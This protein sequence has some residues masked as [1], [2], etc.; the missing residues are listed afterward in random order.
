MEIRQIIEALKKP[1]LAEEHKE[2]TLPGGDRWFY[3]PWE[4]YRERLDEVYPEWQVEYSDPVISGELIAIRCKITIAGISKEGVGNSTAFPEK[5][6]SGNY[7]YGTPLEKACAD[8]FKNAGENWGIARYIS[9][10]A[11]LTRWLH[12]NHDYRA[13]AFARKN[14]QQ[15][16]RPKPGKQITRDEWIAK[17]NEV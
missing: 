16:T 1:F 13:V 7:K 3:I 12:K 10:Q 2:R 9:D 6:K 11:F 8:A 15:Y 4:K 5:T 17:K 14:E